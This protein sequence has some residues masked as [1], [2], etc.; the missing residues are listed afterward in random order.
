MMIL[1]VFN[2]LELRLRAYEISTL[3]LLGDRTLQPSSPQKPDF[4]ILLLFLS[5]TNE[6]SF[7][8]LL[9]LRSSLP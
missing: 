4:D 3:F 8:I 7:D 5:N 2:S 6:R 9:R 1:L